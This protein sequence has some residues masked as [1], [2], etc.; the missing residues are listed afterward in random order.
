MLPSEPRLDT[1]IRFKQATKI[2]RFLTCSGK[3]TIPNALG[4]E[5]EEQYPDRH[6]DD[7]ADR[8][9]GVLRPTEE[10]DPRD[11]DHGARSEVPEHEGTGVG[12]GYLGTQ[13]QDSK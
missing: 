1:M 4:G 2:A 13:K 6:A 7:A 11:T 10:C 5:D 9:D 12:K 3:S 8:G